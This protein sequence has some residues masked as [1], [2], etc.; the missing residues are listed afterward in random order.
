MT[1]FDEN[2]Q[3]IG[4]RPKNHLEPTFDY[5]NCTSRKDILKIKQVLEGWFAPYPE[6]GKADLRSRFRSNIESQHQ[7]AFSELWTHE[8]LRQLGH[9]TEVHPDVGRN[10]HPDFKASCNNGKSFLIEVTTTSD[11]E[12]EVAAQRRID[13][14]YDTLNRLKNPDFFI[15]VV[16]KGKPVSPVPGAKLRGDLEVWL[17]TLS[18][19]QV[20]EAYNQGKFDSIPRYNWKYEGW[21][22][23]FE[24]IPKS[25][26]KRGTQSIR[27]I[28]LTMPLEM[29]QLDTDSEIKAAVAGKDKYG[30]PGLPLVVVLNILGD[31]CDRYDVMSALFGRETFVFGPKG[32]QPGARLHDG[33]WDGPQGPRHRSISAVWVLHSLNAWSADSPNSWL[34]H[35]PWATAPLP[36]DALP[37]S[38]YIPNQKTGHLEETAGKSLPEV[39]KLPV[40][41]PPDE[42]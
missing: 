17:K 21:D 16:D 25:A 10:T 3:S 41:W 35:N 13:Q 24:V 2:P 30:E 42:D 28:G 27:P 29:S 32:S 39:L 18:W 31:F 37:F 38:Q 40:P 5:Y 22:V 8:I 23:R 26:E 6:T 15:A 12:E 4:I 34:V 7:A 1:L 20:S 36:S 33:A 11:S 19:D 9:K 14:V